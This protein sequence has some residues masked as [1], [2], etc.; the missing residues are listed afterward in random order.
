MDK[1]GKTIK[2]LAD[3]F[4]VS[5]QAIHQKRKKEPLSTRLQPFTSTVDGAVYISVDGENLLKQAFEINTV[6]ETVNDVYTSVDGPFTAVDIILET[7]KEQLKVK[8]SQIKDQQNQLVEKE[9]QITELTVA[10]EN[11][12]QTL[13]ASQMLHAGT[14]QQTFLSDTQSEPLKENEENIE[15]ENSNPPKS[16]NF[17]TKIFRKQKHTGFKEVNEKLY[18]FMELWKLKQKGKLQI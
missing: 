17:W 8:D 5:K 9:K 7:L 10:I 14:M 4:G 6:N 16:E 12:T 11:M 13:K 1:K 3:E 18:L 2:Q 15:N